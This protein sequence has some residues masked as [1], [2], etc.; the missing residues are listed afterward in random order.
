MMFVPQISTLRQFSK[1]L[2]L[3]IVAGKFWEIVYYATGLKIH[4]VLQRIDKKGPI[5]IFKD[6]LFLLA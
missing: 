1:N 2:M 4:F 5:L 6:K 3:R